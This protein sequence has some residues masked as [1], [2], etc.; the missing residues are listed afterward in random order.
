MEEAQRI[1]GNRKD[2]MLCGTKEATLNNSDA[3]V[4]VTKWQAFKAPDFDNIKGIT[5]YLFIFDGRNLFEPARMAK[6][7]FTYYSIGRPTF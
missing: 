2:L 3:L 7:G 1:Y 6:K 4:I 5:P